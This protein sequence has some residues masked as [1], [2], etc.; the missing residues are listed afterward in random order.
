MRIRLC[1]IGEL[2]E[3]EMKAV[4]PPE[5]EPVAVYKVEGKFYATDDTCTHA[6]ASLSE[7]GWLDG[8]CVIC[9]VHS[10]EFDIRTGAPLCFPVETPLAVYTVEER[11][12]YVWADIERQA[13]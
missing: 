2:N 11:D 8:H 1:A 6:R 12:G 3:G 13:R 4:R 7:G 5:H 9:P 10:G